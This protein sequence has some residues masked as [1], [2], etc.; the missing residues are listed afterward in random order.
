MLLTAIGLVAHELFTNPGNQSEDLEQAICS[1]L[2]RITPSMLKLEHP[3]HPIEYCNIY[4]SPEFNIGLFVLQKG[5][6]M[7]IHDH[8]NMTVFT[9][10]VYGSLDVKM[11]ELLDPND[12]SPVRKAHVI[13]DKICTSAASLHAKDHPLSPALTHTHDS[14][15]ANETIFKIFPSDGPNLHSYTAVSDYAIMIDVMGPPYAPGLRDITDAIVTYLKVDP[16][17]EMDCEEIVYNGS[18]VY[19]FSRLLKN[20]RPSGIERTMD[21]LKICENICNTFDRMLAGGEGE[22]GVST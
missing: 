2:D 16:S 9:K 15:N 13:S 21:T 12:E 17:V 10:L 3:A 1:L 19:D 18:P 14:A 11:F 4:D 8:P 22:V 20:S 5:E 7:P 6:T